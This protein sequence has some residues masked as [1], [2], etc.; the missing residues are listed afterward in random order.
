MKNEKYHIYFTDAERTQVIQ[1]LIKLKNTLLAQGRYTDA[2]DDVLL[3]LTKA[4][5]KH[6][7]VQHI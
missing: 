1:A 2:V 4:K 7:R 6:L 5:K 3:K